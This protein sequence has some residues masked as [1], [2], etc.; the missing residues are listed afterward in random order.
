MRRLRTRRQKPAPGP[1]TAVGRWLRAGLLN[2]RE[3]KD[4]LF[5]TL[6]SRKPTGWND[7]EA[8][9]VEAACELAAREYFGGDYD[10]R[11]ITS[12]VSQMR[13]KIHSAEPRYL[14]V[15]PPQGGEPGHPARHDSS[16]LSQ[17]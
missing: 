11:A 4:R 13:S 12:L 2:Q 17:G 9:V 3:L 16:P 8:A 14:F 5:R 6:N 15:S 10:V 7:D 1:S